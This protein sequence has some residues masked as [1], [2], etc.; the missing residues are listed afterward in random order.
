MIP[1]PQSAIASGPAAV[2]AV[3]PV[4]KAHHA[5]ALIGIEHRDQEAPYR[6]A[7]S[8]RNFGKRMADAGGLQRGETQSQHLALDGNVQQPLPAIFGAFLLLHISFIDKLL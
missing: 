4:N 2:R 8:P 5:I 3:G 1:S 6:V 7:I